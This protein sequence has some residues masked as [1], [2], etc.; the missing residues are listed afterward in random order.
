M[1]QGGPESTDGTLWCSCFGPSCIKIFQTRIDNNCTMFVLLTVVGTST[2]YR[3]PCHKCRR[4]TV[5]A[6]PLLHSDMTIFCFCVVCSK[7]SILHILCLL[8][9]NP[10]TTLRT[11]MCLL[12][13]KSLWSG[14]SFSDRSWKSLSVS[15]ILKSVGLP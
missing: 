11:T 5:P 14:I 9:I 12:H 4:F 1:I 7:T 3:K 13:Y 10:D 15:E 6:N 8:T 2:D